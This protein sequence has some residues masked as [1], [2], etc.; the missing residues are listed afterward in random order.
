MVVMRMLKA[1]TGRRPH[2]DVFG[3]VTAAAVR[4]RRLTAGFWLVAVVVLLVGVPSL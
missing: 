3:V 4:R 1:T 2:N